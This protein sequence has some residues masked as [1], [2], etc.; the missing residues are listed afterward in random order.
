[1]PGHS[2]AN[3]TATAEDDARRRRSSGS[4]AETFG[5]HARAPEVHS[6]SASRPGSDPRSAAERSVLALQRKAGNQAVARMLA[7]P[8]V[9]F[10]STAQ[11]ETEAESADDEYRVEAGER[12]HSAGHEFAGGGSGAVQRSADAELLAQRTLGESLSRVKRQ[13]GRFLKNK[14][15]PPSTYRWD[16][17]KPDVI[18][19]TG[20]QP[21]KATGTLTLDEHVNNAFASGAKAGQLAKFDSQWVSTGA[22]GMLKKLDPVFAQKVM[23]THLYRIDTAIAGQSGKFHDANAHFDKIGKN[24]PYASQREWTKEGGIAPQA[25]VNYMDGMDFI[26]Q[27]D[28]TTGAPDEAQLTELEGDAPTT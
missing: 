3:P 1:M 18:A 14:K 8:S 20:F 6:G 26:N 16:D 13:V 2:K 9:A 27:Y 11:R 5:S 4:S 24:R 28:M 19:Q 25:V 10:Q 17:R 12:G 23:N 22:Y 15:L 7:G 21:W